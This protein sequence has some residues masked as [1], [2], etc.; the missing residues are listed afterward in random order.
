MSP[1]VRWRALGFVGAG[2]LIV[3]LGPGA[4]IL[5]DWLVDGARA[6]QAG[7]VQID[8]VSGW[9]I[10]D[11]RAGRASIADG[12]GVWAKA[13]GVRLRWRPWSLALGQI[14]VSRLEIADVHVQRVPSVDV[15][16][17]SP[18]KL[19][20]RLRALEVAQ[21]RFGTSGDLYAAEG[22]VHL[23]AGKLGAADIS[24]TPKG[25]GEDAL[26]VTLAGDDVAVLMR[27]KAGGAF[28][29]LLG[30][31]KAA[32]ATGAFKNGV[33]AATLTIGAEVAAT[34]TSAR[35]PDGVQLRGEVWPTRMARFRDAPPPARGL[36]RVD[37]EISGSD[38]SARIATDGAEIR[39]NAPRKRNA[40]IAVHADIANIRAWDRRAN[41]GHVRFTGQMQTGLILAG[42]VEV[43][44]VAALKL[45]ARGPFRVHRDGEAW[46]A[47]A[48]LAVSAEAGAGEWVQRETAKSTVSIDAA[49]TGGGAIHLR[50]I[51]WR[52]EALEVKGATGKNGFEGRW[53][54]LNMARLVPDLKGTAAGAW[55]Y[56]DRVVTL[57]GLATSLSSANP[58]LARLGARADISGA[59]EIDR[60]G[61]EVRAFRVDGANLRAGAR[62]RIERGVLDLALESSVR[63]PVRIGDARIDGLVDATGRV[64]GRLGA[65]QV[66]LYVDLPAL[67]VSDSTIRDV[68]ARFSLD[69]DGERRVGAIDARGMFTQAP[70]HVQG[71]INVGGQ[72]V[73][74]PAVAIEWRGMTLQGPLALDAKGVTADFAISG[75]A[76]ALQSGLGGSYQGRVRLAPGD[77]E[78]MITGAVDWKNGAVG[79]LRFDSARMDLSGPLPAISFVAVAQS[80]DRVDHVSFS[81]DGL[82]RGGAVSV[83]ARGRLA[84]EHFATRAPAQFTISPLKAEASVTI[85][86]GQADFAIAESGSAVTFD[87]RVAQAPLAPLSSFIG[88]RLSGVASGTARLV[89]RESVFGGEIDASFADLRVRRR[90]ADPI[91][92]RVQARLSN[93]RLTGAVNATSQT[94]LVARATFDAPLKM[95]VAPLRIAPDPA[96]DGTLSWDIAGPAET[97]WPLF[98]P[99]DQDFGGKLTAKGD[100]RFAP[101][102]LTGSG[103]ITLE[104]GRFEDKESGLRLRDMAARVT[105]NE[106][107]ARLDAFSANDSQ[108]GSVRAT[109]VVS[110]PAAGAIELTLARL[111]LLG[112]QEAKVRASGALQLTWL[113]PVVRMGGALSV[114]EAV[115]SPQQR[116]A[117]SFAELDVIEINKPDRDDDNGPAPTPKAPGGARIN[118][119]FTLRADGRTF[120]RGRGLDSEWSLDTRVRGAADA[121]RLSGEARL[122]RGDC[123]LAGRAFDLERGRVTLDGALEDARIDVIAVREEDD[124][125]ARVELTGQLRDPKAKLT[126][127]PA[128]PEDEILPQILFGRA[129]ASLSPVEA[130]QA[131]AGLAELTGQSAFNIAGLARDLV[132][133]DRLDV[134]GSAAGAVRIAGGKYLTRNVYL[135]VARTGVGTTESQ[136]EWRVRP[137]FLIISSFAE[138]GDRRVSVRW[139]REY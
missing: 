7:R 108:G 77:G 88:T 83:N 116:A 4:P 54:A 84:G 92:A 91:A 135:E 129:G 32:S 8:R 93:A 42:D 72:A 79:P 41:A 139:R 109:G 124:L 2:A 110:G 9:W 5:V 34:M 26:N 87:A 136:V 98:G 102:R 94:G 49:R 113:G 70:L 122:L 123:R 128:M 40:P 112:R 39:F 96:R 125:T 86:Q 74:S 48:D 115:L 57:D 56:A 104:S 61:M 25:R 133:L 67:G 53:R 20:V 82:I 59:L 69:R 15:A 114:D 38:S 73:L 121:P 63:G 24:I 22:A 47:I 99:L 111:A 95:Q 46:R 37:A 16:Q 10:G 119:D 76:P 60:A 101:R 81:A 132:G 51:V 138:D 85:G 103:E 29:Q 134:R 126:S 105:V 97:V 78:T 80:K 30:F 131:A 68:T 27:A 17:T 18:S 117:R 89:A 137:R 3:A 44:D 100:V 19:S 12:K 107:G 1:R 11:L 71:P 118:L 36:W 50:N 65:E 66:V 43:A 33:G 64:R 28:D 106:R 52:A 14:D 21:A 62:G 120:V 45:T 127:T 23:N 6:G 90:A 75:S 35:T 31:G 130:A 58:V 55:S 13:E